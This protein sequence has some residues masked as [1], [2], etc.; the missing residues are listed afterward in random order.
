ML[1]RYI[2]MS[3]NLNEN[4]LFEVI[5][6]YFEYETVTLEDIEYIERIGFNVNEF[7]N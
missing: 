3:M 1:E 6:E 2:D 5:E 7:L 4:D